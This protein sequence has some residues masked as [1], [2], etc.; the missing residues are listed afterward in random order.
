MSNLMPAQSLPLLLTHVNA[1]LP[2]H[3]IVRL[4]IGVDVSMHRSLLRHQICVLCADCLEFAQ[5]PHCLMPPP[6]CH[7]QFII[8]G[9]GIST[10]T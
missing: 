4:E 8:L 2:L 10:C 9:F 5:K 3:L 6:E 7:F 1:R